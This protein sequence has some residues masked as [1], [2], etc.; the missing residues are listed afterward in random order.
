MFLFWRVFNKL[1][2]YCGLFWADVLFPSGVC[3]TAGLMWFAVDTFIR[4]R[5]EVGMVSGDTLWSS[6][7]HHVSQELSIPPHH[8][9]IG[10]FWYTRDNLRIGPVLLAGSGRR[11]LYFDLSSHHTDHQACVSEDR[12]RWDEP[13][14]MD[15]T[16]GP[17]PYSN[18]HPTKVPWWKDLHINTESV[19][20]FEL[21]Y[22]SI[23]VNQ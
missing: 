1:Q 3:G 8:S 23:K 2:I 19:S 20:F 12:C 13:S 10:G 11:G 4:Y 5:Q 9:P 6:S 7:P 14:S 22:L 16:K 15:S 18:Q 21:T 17:K